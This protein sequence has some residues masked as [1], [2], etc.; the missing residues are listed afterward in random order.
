MDFLFPER[1]K[2]AGEEVLGLLLLGE[3]GVLDGRE[4]RRHLQPIL[5]RDLLHQRVHLQHQARPDQPWFGTPEG[6][7]IEAFATPV[8][9]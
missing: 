8:S 7:A 9:D 1:S 4:G 5:V 6:S 3:D 2:S